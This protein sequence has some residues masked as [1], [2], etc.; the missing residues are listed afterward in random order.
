[1]KIDHRWRGPL[2]DPE[3]DLLHAEAFAHALTSVPWNRRLSRHSIGWVT[4]RSGDDLVGFVN[5]VGDGGD[6]AVLLDLAVADDA[7]GR[8]VGTR[9]VREACDGARTLGC[10]WVHVDFVESLV[11]F[12]RDAC[13]FAGTAAGLLALR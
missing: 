4:A 11:P 1:M 2:S 12:Y 6:H 8:G 5:L 3:L 10:Q 7:R 13:G 9:L